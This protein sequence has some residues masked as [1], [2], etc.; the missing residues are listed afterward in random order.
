VRRLHTVSTGPDVVR[1]VGT[2]G[3]TGKRQNITKA[4]DGVLPTH[5]DNLQT[6]TIYGARPSESLVVGAGTVLVEPSDRAIQIALR[7]AL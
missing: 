2:D 5:K 4:R 7:L 1:N 3:A 6:T